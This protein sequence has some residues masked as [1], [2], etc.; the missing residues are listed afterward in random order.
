MGSHVGLLVRNIPLLDFITK[1]LLSAVPESRVQLESYNTVNS[2]KM[3][4]TPPWMYGWEDLS[5]DVTRQ[6]DLMEEEEEFLSLLREAQGESSEEQSR[7]GSPR[8]QS[9]DISDFLWDWSS[10]PNIEPPKQ[11]RLQSKCCSTTSLSAS[12][13]TSQ[14]RETTDKAGTHSYVSLLISNIISLIIG[15]SIGVWLY[16][17][18]I[19][20]HS[21]FLV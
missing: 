21:N 15:T 6:E 12:R 5:C 1:A 19:F 4:E 3:S 9:S 16:K 10:T 17:R 20:K 8:P 18:N 7:L 11:W 14:D 13:K 2:Y